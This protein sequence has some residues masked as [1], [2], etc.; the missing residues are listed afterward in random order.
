MFS[1]RVIAAFSLILAIAFGAACGKEG[2]AAPA[3][4]LWKP[5]GNEGNISGVINFTGAVPAPSKLDMSSDSKCEG[6][7]FLDDVIVKD[8][9]LQN[10]FVFVKSGLPQATFETPTDAFTLDQKGCKYVPR[11]LG[12]HAGQPMKSVNSQK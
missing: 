3:A 2:P 11:V 1:R 9:K 12:A 4:P 10:A 6:E 5:S 8:G 7:N